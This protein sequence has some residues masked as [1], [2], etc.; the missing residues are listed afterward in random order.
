LEESLRCGID[1]LLLAFS[2]YR[3]RELFRRLIV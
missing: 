3:I 1:N 2:R